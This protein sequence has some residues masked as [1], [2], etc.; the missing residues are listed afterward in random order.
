[1]EQEEAAAS[2]ASVEPPSLPSLVSLALRSLCPPGSPPAGG[3]LPAPSPDALAVLDFL[4]ASSADASLLERC[5][6]LVDGGR[7]RLCESPGGRV[8]PQV[9]SSFSGG[10]RSGDAASAGAGGGPGDAAAP[11]RA[12]SGLRDGPYT[13]VGGMCSCAASTSA[14]VR[15]ESGRGGLCKHVLA[16]EVAVATG[17]WVAKAVSDAEAV[18]LADVW[19]ARFKAQ[20]R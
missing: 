10:G 9:A 15:G 12:A 13:V 16:V 18:A 2:G 7:V 6:E 19:G 8:I 11:D 14:L 5:L 4:L 20:G 17:R 3:P 1:M